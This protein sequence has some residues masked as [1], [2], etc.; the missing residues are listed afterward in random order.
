M[1]GLNGVVTQRTSTGFR[2]GL[3]GETRDGEDSGKRDRSKREISQWLG[4]GRRRRERCIS[5]WLSRDEEEEDEEEGR[6]GGRVGSR[7]CPRE[8]RGGRGCR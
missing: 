5:Q 8:G 3:V 7:L 4:G 1:S 2:G 6:V